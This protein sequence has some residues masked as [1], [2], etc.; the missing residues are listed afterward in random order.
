MPFYFKS[1]TWILLGMIIGFD[2]VFRRSEYFLWSAIHYHSLNRLQSLAG[3][4]NRHGQ[5]LT[6]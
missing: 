2:E 6:P 4:E 1:F 5:A 3:K